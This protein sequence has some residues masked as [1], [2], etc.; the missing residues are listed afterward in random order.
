[1]EEA[2][3]A[4]L[5]EILG[6]HVDLSLAGDWIDKGYDSG[7]ARELSASCGAGARILPR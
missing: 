5:R 7:M 3:R 1:M 4:S 6:D 2:L